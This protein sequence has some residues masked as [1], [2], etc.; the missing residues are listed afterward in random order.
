MSG[1]LQPREEITPRAVPLDYNWAC[2]LGIILRPTSFD[3]S[4]CDERGDERGNGPLYS[5][6]P[7]SEIVKKLDVERLVAGM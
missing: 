3:T 2:E 5:G 7:L 1:R 4:I 6:V